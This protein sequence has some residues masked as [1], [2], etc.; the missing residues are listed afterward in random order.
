V[1]RV[2]HEDFETT[3]GCIRE[4]K[5]MRQGFGDVVPTLPLL[6]AGEGVRL[7]IA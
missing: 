4:A 6:L 5:T 3:K 2:G 7:G 1:A